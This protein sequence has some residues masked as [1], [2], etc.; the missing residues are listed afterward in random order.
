MESAMTSDTLSIGITGA[1]GRMGRAL[2]A[3]VLREPQARLGDACV[4]P[5]SAAVGT[6]ILD[7]AG[8]RSGVVAS[9]HA[10]AMFAACAVV[11]DFSAPDATATFAHL[12][13]ESHTPLVVGTT[14]LGAEEETA[15]K[16]AA[17]HSALLHAAN[18]SLGIH[19]LGRLVREAASRLDEDFDIEILEM[20]HRYK[21]D[22]PSGTALA[23]GHA[24]A[25]GRELPHA[26]AEEAAAHPDRGGPRKPG[27]IGFSVLR[28]GD[29]AGEHSVIFAGPQERLELTHRATS[30]SI[31][32]RGAVRAALWLAKQ[33]PG[34]Y[35]LDDLFKD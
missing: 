1:S 27:S 13:A 31:F 14:G 12:A 4:R 6:A 30:R 8:N 10:P 20:H 22:A 26:T 35:S 19:L 32:A 17:R 18:F 23:L 9:D 7:A 34:F 15:L 2:A 5:G 33:P 11:I 25:Q 28:G 21:R 29:V 16:D 3:A 24:A